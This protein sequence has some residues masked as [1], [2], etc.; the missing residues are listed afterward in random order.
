MKT[1]SKDRRIM[2]RLIVSKA[3]IRDLLFSTGC[4]SFLFQE[5][6]TIGQRKK[7]ISRSTLE[8]KKRKKTASVEGDHNNKK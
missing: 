6:V 2:L 8:R 4:L 3:R 5:S 1:G 7:K